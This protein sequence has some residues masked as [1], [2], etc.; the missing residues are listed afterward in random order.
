MFSKTL[1]RK[2]LL[3]VVLLCL[4]TEHVSAQQP[5][6]V[7]LER[8]AEMARDERFEEAIAI[9]LEVIDQLTGSEAAMTN[10]KLGVAFRQTGRLPE[11]WFF[12]SGYLSSDLGQNDVTAAGWL[13]DVESSMSHTHI[14]V[15]IQCS[16]KET[17][18]HV[19]VS[20][21]GTAMPST[22]RVRSPSFSWWFPPGEHRL[23]AVATGHVTK[24]VPISVNSGGGPSVKWITLSPVQTVSSS[25]VEPVAP[26]VPTL[27]A[28]DKRSK[29]SRTAEIMLIGAGA[30]IGVAG[31][32]VNLRAHLTNEDL[33][34]K[35]E[36]R[37]RYP[38]AD[39]AKDAYDVDYDDQVMPS[40]SGAYALYGIGGAAIL[41]GL[42]TWAVRDPGGNDDSRSAF[43]VAPFTSP[44]GWG[45][46]MTMEW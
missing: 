19:P 36:D 18:T 31:A 26:S 16:P 20:L 2:A 1:A 22:I 14:K 27:L 43:G 33:V 37:K 5:P 24:W 30:A 4:S 46:V 45:A 42:L 32:F 25:P 12:L 38:D 11:A 9:W 17:V 13:A 35:Y 28:P 21:P 44:E 10:K 29:G 23:G 40:L 3:A 39:D 7:M 8:A 41:A 6:G 34:N 15:T